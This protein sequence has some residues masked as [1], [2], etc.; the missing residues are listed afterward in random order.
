M[1]TILMIAPSNLGGAIEGLPSGN[2]YLP[3]ASGLVSAALADVGTLMMLGFAPA[4]SSIM[5]AKATLSSAQLLGCVSSPVLIIP[6]PG[7]NKYIA[8]LFAMFRYVFVSAPYSGFDNNAGIYY[9]T[10]YNA[11]SIVAASL[12]NVMS[13]SYSAWT[14][15]ASGNATPEGTGSDEAYLNQGIYFTDPAASISGGNGTLSITL[16]YTIETGP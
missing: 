9:G 3:N 6:A 5:T 4:S 8:I 2:S 1:S 10:S 14:Q 15:G 13:E 7:S 11:G 12:T 16:K